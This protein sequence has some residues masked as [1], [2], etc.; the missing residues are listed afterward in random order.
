M[1]N[2]ILAAALALSARAQ[3]IT[4]PRASFITTALQSP[5]NETRLGGSTTVL[6]GR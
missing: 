6:A 5:T 4:A 1:L 3:S 2:R